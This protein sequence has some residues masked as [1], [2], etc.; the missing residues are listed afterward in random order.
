MRRIIERFA[1]LP[2]LASALVLPSLA[3]A[4]IQLRGLDLSDDPEEE[5]AKGET[6]QRGKLGLDLSEDEGPALP[7]VFEGLDLSDEEEGEEGQRLQLALGLFRERNFEAAALGFYEILQDPAEAAQH[8]EAQY[9]LAKSL[10]RLGMYH[11]ALS[12]FKDILGQGPSNRFHA[13]SL[14]WLFFIANRTTN[15]SVVL[16]EIARFAGSEFPERYQEEYRFLLAKYNFVRA[17]ALLDAGSQER[18]EARQ[19][20]WDESRRSFEEARRLA[21][22]IPAASRFHA[23]AR[24]LDGLALY[25]LERFAPALESFKEVVRTLNPRLDGLQDPVLREQ[26]F[27]QLARIHFEHGQM[28]AANFYYSRIERGS[29][30][31]LQS[32]YE[33]AWSYFRQG[34][35]EK[36]L[37]NLITIRSPFFRDEYYPEALILEAVIYYENCRYPEA[38]ETIDE[39]QRRYG[40][41]HEALEGLLSRSLATPADYYQ[42]LADLQRD[43]ESAAETDQMLVRILKLALADKELG[44]LDDSIRE[45][46]EEIDGIGGR[47]EFFRHSAL[48]KKLI[49]ELEGQ[50]VGLLKRAGFLTQRKLHREHR[51]LGNLLYR[52]LAIRAEIGTREKDALEASLRQGQ[53]VTVVRDVRLSTAV[54]D[55]HVY[56]PFE[57]EYWRDEL[58]TYEYTLTQGCKE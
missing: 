55:E 30:Q 16:D 9:L 57:G 23:R 28:D 40:P 44:H 34:Q 24:Y 38:R 35:Y 53:T 5:E 33:S 37:G 7:Q 19:T 22:M 4:Q 45:M 13:L 17:R 29:E 31:W 52:A 46:E 54:D 50:R 3:G 6:P 10:Y 11:S 56:W 1:L 26:A 41:L 25:V 58:G 42:V 8:A 21:A 36:A 14:E 43:D 12:V 20:Y 15:Q 32:L 47:R 51:E 49:D 2:L 18:G 39:F 27:M 48:A